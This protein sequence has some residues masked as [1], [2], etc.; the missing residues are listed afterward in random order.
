MKLKLSSIAIYVFLLKVITVYAFDKTQLDPSRDVYPASNLNFYTKAI[1]LAIN[2]I[3]KIKREWPQD[4]SAYSQVKNSRFKIIVL[5]RILSTKDIMRAHYARN[6]SEYQFSQHLKNVTPDMEMN[7][8]Y[9]SNCEPDELEIIG[10]HMLQWPRDCNFRFSLSGI[11]VDSNKTPDYI[12]YLNVQTTDVILDE[13]RRLKKNKD[14]LLELILIKFSSIAFN[15]NKDVAL[16]YHESVRLSMST[17]ELTAY[18]GGKG[19]A[20]TKQIT[21]KEL[22]LT[23]FELKESADLW[24]GMD[25][26]WNI[27]QNKL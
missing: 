8:L 13:I 24:D 2:E 6:S 14:P 10:K 11:P 1:E 3:D 9:V 5:N 20:F 25:S 16:I 27:L 15:R 23:E 12:E 17:G 7:L 4:S 26:F 18:E 19:L 21:N 22:N